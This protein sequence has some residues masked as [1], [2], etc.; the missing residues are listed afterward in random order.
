[1]AIGRRDVLKLAGGAGVGLAASPVP[2]NLLHDVTIWTQNW[3]WIPKLSRGESQTRF[4]SCT[5]CPAA[6]AMQARCVAGYPVQLAAVKEG[7]SAALCPMG[8]AA[9]HLPYVPDRLRN[10]VVRGRRTPTDAATAELKQVLEEALVEPDAG[11]VAILDERPGRTASLLYRRFL[12]KYSHGA[13]LIAPARRDSTLTALAALQER[14]D[15]RLALDFSKVKTLVSFAAP[16]MDGWLPPARMN[17]RKL[18][19]LRLVQVEACCS[20]T[21]NRAEIW[22]AARPGSEVA[23]AFGLTHVLLRDHLVPAATLKTLENLDAYRAVVAEFSPQH[24]ESITGVPAARIEEAARYIAENGPAAAIGGGDPATGPLGHDEE[25]AIAALNLLLGAASGAASPI[26]AAGDVPVPASLQDARRVVPQELADVPDGSI[27]LLLI[28]ASAPSGGVPWRMVERKLARGRATVACFASFPGTRAHYSQFLIP[29]VCFPEGWEDSGP[30]LDEA[31]P[32]YRVSMPLVP[33][34]EGAM[35]LPQLLLDLEG[36]G[37][38]LESLLEERAAAIHQ[39]GKGV[40]VSYSAGTEKAVSEYDSPAEVWSALQEGAMWVGEA[41]KAAERSVRSRLPGALPEERTRLIAAGQGRLARATGSDQ[42]YPLILTPAGWGAA[43]EHV[44]SPL[45]A[46][47]SRE[48]TLREHCG[49]VAL[50]QDTAGDAKLRHG[51]NALVQ[52]PCGSCTMRVR[53][54]DTVMPGVLRL[55]VAPASA[56]PPEQAEICN[57]DDDCTWRLTRAQIRRA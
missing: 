36:A 50:H 18:S 46:K 47:L 39:A 25:N 5:L 22:L 26:V 10:A 2:Y 31:A 3:S 23:L 44:S 13:Y 56:G 41:P 32:T 20:R 29:T 21:A 7:G 27:R 14:T 35:S 49:E 55:I 24:V 45:M 1:M 16:V 57:V 54:D 43:P 12:S 53:V 34:L 11:S 17:E 9:H 4:T 33:A 52:T 15:Q 19:S 37:A 40:L 28:D 48:T 6:C 8:L 30:A 38:G 51:G 42:Q